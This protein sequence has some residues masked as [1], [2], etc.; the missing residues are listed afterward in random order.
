MTVSYGMGSTFKLCCGY[1]FVFGPTLHDLGPVGLMK[2][3]ISMVLVGDAQQ[4]NL[5]SHENIICFR[6]LE[7]VWARFDLQ[8]QAFRDPV[9]PAIMYVFHSHQSPVNTFGPPALRTI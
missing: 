2:I 1:V 5:F 4:E 7:P 9:G 3:S 8:K 6:V